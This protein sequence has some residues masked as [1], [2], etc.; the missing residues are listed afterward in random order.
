[1]F[2]T[3]KFL[4]SFN[5]IYERWMITLIR[6]LS[7]YFGVFRPYLL[8][9][10]PQKVNPRLKRLDS[11]VVSNKN[12]EILPSSGLGPRSGN[13]SQNGQKSTPLMTSTI[14]K[15]KHKTKNFFSADSKIRRVVWGFDQLSSSSTEIPNLGYI[16]CKTTTNRLLDIRSESTFIVLK[17]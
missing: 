11:S 4:L 17:L 2:D 8:N 7:N 5:V 9:P 12:F 6:R 1:M 16:Y 10:E 3:V 14:K 13:L 15:T